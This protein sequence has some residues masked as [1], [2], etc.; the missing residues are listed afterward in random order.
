MCGGGD[1]SGGGDSGGGN[2]NTNTADIG[3]GAGQIDPGLAS[4]A[5]INQGDDISDKGNASR[6]AGSA[7]D[8]TTASDKDSYVSDSLSS[9]GYS[10]N[11]KGV[12]DGKGNAVTDG[13]GNPVRSGS[14]AEAEARASNEY[15]AYQDYKEARAEA[16][17]AFYSDMEARQQVDQDMIDVAMNMGGYLGGDFYNPDGTINESYNPSDVDVYAGPPSLSNLDAYGKALG[18]Y[19][20]TFS[21]PGY[22]FEDPY[23]TAMSNNLATIDNNLLGSNV[24]TQNERNYFDSFASGYNDDAGFLGKQIEADL[25]NNIGFSTAGQRAGDFLGG[26]LLGMLGSAIAGPVGGAIASGLQP[27]TMDLYGTTQTPGYGVEVSTLG[28]NPG[29]ALGNFLGGEV[30]GAVAPKVAGAVYDSTGNVNSA[31]G[32]GVG[33]G[34]LGSQI[35]QQGGT[36]AAQGMG[37]TP[38][39]ISSDI[40]SSP[41]ESQVDDMMEAQGF[42]SRLDSGDDSGTQSVAGSAMPTSNIGSTDPNMGTAVGDT[43]LQTVASGDVGSGGILPGD[44]TAEFDADSFIEET[45]QLSNPNAQQLISLFGDAVNDLSLNPLFSAA[46]A[47]VQYLSKGRQRDYGNAIYNVQNKLRNQA[48]ARRRQLGDR[49]VGMII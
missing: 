46:P 1:D 44:S 16:Q 7:P 11:Y 43:E 32:A 10:D 12:S 26:S 8:V 45:A 18:G 37:I 21:F 38:S 6:N 23:G 28:F 29:G 5:G 14:Y 35:G 39:V 48:G 42:G 47:G 3:Y 33:A 9:K 40:Q 2:T 27:N 31:I 4:A 19:A 15:D 24:V 22:T 17:E 36:L 20:D 49:L 13:F 41:Y 30:A 25:N 34:V